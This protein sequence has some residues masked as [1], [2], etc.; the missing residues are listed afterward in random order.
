[1]AL[2]IKLPEWLTEQRIA[3]LLLDV[4]EC[5]N[6]YTEEEVSQFALDEAFDLRRYKAYAAKQ[7]LTHYG[8]IS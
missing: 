2:N 7:I 6:P 3:E 5:Q 4:S 1:M 8:I